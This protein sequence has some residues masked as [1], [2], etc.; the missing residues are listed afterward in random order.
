MDKAQCVAVSAGSCTVVYA[1]IPGD[2]ERTGEIAAWP[3]IQKPES[4]SGWWA[5]WHRR[6]QG[7]GLSTWWPNSQPAALRQQRQRTGCRPRPCS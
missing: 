3:L 6:S 2:F 7:A 1:P 5:A 4:F